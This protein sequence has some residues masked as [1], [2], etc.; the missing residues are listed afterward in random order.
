MGRREA[1]PELRGEKR[2]RERAEL[3]ERQALLLRF[4]RRHEVQFEEEHLSEAL[5]ET[6]APLREM[7][8]DGARRRA[9]KYLSRRLSDE[10]WAELSACDR[11]RVAGEQVNAERE[12]MLELKVEAL[13]AGNAEP[14]EL[15]ERCDDEQRRQLRQLTLRARREAGGERAK[16]SRRRLLRC[17]RELHEGEGAT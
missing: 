3:Q 12:K 15:S 9:F 7:G 2:A 13:I 11:A 6:L 10:D 5:W 16:A 1:A 17:L 4:V 8:A 14:E